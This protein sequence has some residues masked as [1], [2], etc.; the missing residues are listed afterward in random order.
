MYNFIFW[1]FYKY[2]EWKDKD[3]STFIPSALVIFSFIIHLFFFYS[4][5][6]ISTH[7]NPLEWG[8]GLSYGQRKYLGFPFVMLL[9]FIIW[10][11]YYRKKAR[12]ILSKYEGKKALTAKNIVLVLLIMVVPLIIAIKLTNLSIG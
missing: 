8:S 7:S 6:R 11:F 12:Q 1:F 4:V 9:F 5:Y 2:F 3:D 10:Y